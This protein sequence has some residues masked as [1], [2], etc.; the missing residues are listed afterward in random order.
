MEMCLCGVLL[1]AGVVSA[2]VGGPHGGM[3]LGDKTYTFEVKVAPEQGHVTIYSLK[4][5]RGEV[6]RTMTVVLYQDPE[7]QEMVE[8]SAVSPPYA[9]YVMY[10]GKLSP[11]QL[12]FMGV[13]I[14]FSIE[15]GKKRI[16]R[17]ASLR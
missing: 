16:I 17:S 3:I 13:E 4:P 12:A 14:R 6:P 8:V 15:P 10:Q 11:K 2:M 7:T 5:K 9:D 1:T